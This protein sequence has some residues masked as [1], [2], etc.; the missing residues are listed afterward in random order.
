MDRLAFNIDKIKEI[1]KKSLPEAI[2]KE[3]EEMIL[4]GAIPP[5]ERIN[6]T[7]LAS[8]LG[9][10]RAPI[11]EALRQLESSGLL[12][13]QTNK[14]MYVREIRIDE[15][16]DLYDI[17]VALDGLAGEKAAECIQ[18]KDL[19][20]L[21]S[22]IDEMG[23]WVGEHD[24]KAYFRANLAFHMAI[25]RI[26]RNESLV[27][28]Y[29]SVCKQTS[30]FRMITLSLPGRLSLSLEKHRKII[31]ALRRKDGPETAGLLKIHILEAKEALIRAMKNKS[32]GSEGKESP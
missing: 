20:L 2:F 19:Q 11:R 30:L 7:K 12:Q 21:E 26:A 32:D 10:S 8:I 3:L 4:S 24:P 13:I 18:E 1:Q 17:R 23:K 31:E 28:M 15:V 29:E 9:V 22:L 27:G 14:G 5:G 25:V 6:E 16:K